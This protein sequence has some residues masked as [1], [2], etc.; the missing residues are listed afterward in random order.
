MSGEASGTVG[1]EIGE[2][3][4]FDAN[5]RITA[6]IIPI[7]LKFSCALCGATCSVELP[8][9][10]GAIDVELPDCPLADVGEISI[11]FGP[12]ALPDAN[13]IAPL[14]GSV[15]G[16]IS[17]VYADGSKIADVSIAATFS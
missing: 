11:P 3:A 6:S 7:T 1:K 12:L 9:G 15:S 2:G 4:S 16:T 10:I 13:P 8:L 17:A 14:S 5:L